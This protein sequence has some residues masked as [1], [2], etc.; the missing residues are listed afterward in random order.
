LLLVFYHLQAF[1]KTLT[2]VKEDL[3]VP[4]I[5]CAFPVESMDELQPARYIYSQPCPLSSKILLK[6]APVLSKLLCLVA[7]GCHRFA[8]GPFTVL[9]IHDAGSGYPLSPQLCC[10]NSLCDQMVNHVGTAPG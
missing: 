6:I 8:T 7:G 2:L 4:G 9:M 5:S 3:L 1:E 10:F